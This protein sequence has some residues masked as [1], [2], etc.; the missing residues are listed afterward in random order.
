MDVIHYIRYKAV[1][2][3]AHTLQAFKTVSYCWRGFMGFLAT[4]SLSPFKTSIILLLH[5]LFFV[6]G[7]KMDFF[8]HF[9]SCYWKYLM[10]LCDL[11]HSVDTISH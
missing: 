9:L 3:Q 2:N 8:F 10:P 5:L 6:L 11:K 7:G 1:E 4:P